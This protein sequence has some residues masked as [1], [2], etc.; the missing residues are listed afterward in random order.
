MMLEINVLDQAVHQMPPGPVE[1]D[2]I[3]IV[4]PSSTGATDLVKDI[5]G[6]VFVIKHLLS[7]LVCSASFKVMACPNRSFS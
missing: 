6:A 7:K 2:P 5:I 1:T 3:I 4:Q